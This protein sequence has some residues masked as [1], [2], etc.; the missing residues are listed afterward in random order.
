[1]CS[2]PTIDFGEVINGQ[3]FEYVENDRV[4]FKCHLGYELEGSDW[5]EC[6]EKK[7]VPPLRCLGK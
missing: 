6:K 4:Q 1:M 5:I 2:A 3:K 7:W